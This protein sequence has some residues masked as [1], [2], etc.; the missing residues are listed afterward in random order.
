M[1]IWER[2]EDQ[3]GARK[4]DT[5]SAMVVHEGDR[6]AAAI[7][8]VL[9]LP[10]DVGE[11]RQL[12]AAY[13]QEN[14][15]LQEEVSSLRNDRRNLQKK[16]SCCCQINSNSKF[17]NLEILYSERIICKLVSYINQRCSDWTRNS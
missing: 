9:E 10:E 2:L 11:L 8:P 3:D 16:V 13:R 5:N 6:N 4:D 7:V 15:Q 12:C 14:D 17:G 1:A